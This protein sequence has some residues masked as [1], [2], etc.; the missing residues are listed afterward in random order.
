MNEPTTNDPAAAIVTAGGIRYQSAAT[1]VG[2]DG[3]W[4]VLL[5][6]IAERADEGSH[7]VTAFK[8]LVHDRR[9]ARQYRDPLGLHPRSSAWRIGKPASSKTLVVDARQPRR[10]FTRTFCAGELY[11]ILHGDP[12][13]ETGSYFELAPL[14]EG[15]DLEIQVLVT[16]VPRGIRG[17]EIARLR[18]TVAPSC[19]IDLMPGDG[20][21]HWLDSPL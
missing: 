11:N 9:R 1:A 17:A 18:V 8:C 16:S 12:P 6:V 10:T 4:T 13:G 2:V 21:P 20:E 5:D 19:H 15:D 7:S 3:K 14:G